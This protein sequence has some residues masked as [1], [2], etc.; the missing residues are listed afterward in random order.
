MNRKMI[1]IFVLVF[2]KNVNA[3]EH[4]DND[5]YDRLGLHKDATGK[6]IEDSFY[7]YTQAYLRCAM[8]L[9][10]SVCEGPEKQ[11]GQWHEAYEILKDPLQRYIYDNGGLDIIRTFREQ[12]RLRALKPTRNN[13]KILDKKLLLDRGDVDSSDNEPPHRILSR[14]EIEQTRKLLRDKDKMYSLDAKVNINLNLNFLIEKLFVEESCDDVK[15]HLFERQPYFIKAL[16]YLNE[17][18]EK[19]EFEQKIIQFYVDFA[20]RLFDLNSCDEGMKIVN[21][22][23]ENYNME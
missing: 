14:R 20:K 9:P 4:T 19:K 16:G 5:L 13:S 7:I 21:A 11:Y 23:L 15:E 8:A 6:A 2:F 1:F 18:E 17:P 12:Q 22:M 3:M 10:C